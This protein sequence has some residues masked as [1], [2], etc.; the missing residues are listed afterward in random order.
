M[1]G[2][3]AISGVTIA[4]STF[5]WTAYRV[6]AY[7]SGLSVQHGLTAGIYLGGAASALVAVG[8]YSVV[9]KYLSIHPETMYKE[10][11]RRVRDDIAVTELLGG[12]AQPGMFKAYAYKGGP[13]YKTR[14]VRKNLFDIF[15]FERYGL[16]LIYQIHGAPDGR[17]AMVSAMATQ[18]LFGGYHIASSWNPPPPPLPIILHLRAGVCVIHVAREGGRHFV[19]ART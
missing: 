15:S 12:K 5:A 10:V 3:I 8:G 13:V 11:H 4:V 17:M 16:Q 1:K 6:S 14:E 9:K 18:S 7:V 19:L 2:L